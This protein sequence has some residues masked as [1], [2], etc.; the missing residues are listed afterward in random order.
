MPEHDAVPEHGSSMTPHVHRLR[1]AY[2]D[3]DQGGIVHH[4]SY[5][6]YLEAARIEMLRERGVDY[7]GLEKDERLGLAVAN[8]TLRYV[9]PARFDDLLDVSTAIGKVGAASITLNNTI[10]REGLRLHEATLTLACL[11]LS[12]A[13]IKRLPA[14]LIDRLTPAEL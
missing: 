14:A 13:Q 4:A 7:R 12:T 1:V 6:R 9:R 11:D 2:S 5:L 10:E 8:M 3:T